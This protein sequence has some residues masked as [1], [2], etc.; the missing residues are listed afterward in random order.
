M[1]ETRT[2]QVYKVTELSEKAKDHAFYRWLEYDSY[3]WQDE[4]RDTLDSFCKLFPVKVAHWEYDD[5][6]YSIRCEL[7][8]YCY[9]PVSMSGWR[10]ATYIWNNYGHVLF[11]GKYYSK[12]RYVDGKYQYKSRTSKIILNPRN[13][14]LTGFCRDEDMLDPVYDFLQKPDGTTFEELM[15]ACCEAWGRACMQ[16]MEASTTMEAFEEFCET[17]DMLFDVSGRLF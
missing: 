2:I 12:G 16:D 15:K 8:D 5:L 17:N 7:S 3:S 9:A 6:H 1:P 11:P 4:N 10:L 14:C 13:C